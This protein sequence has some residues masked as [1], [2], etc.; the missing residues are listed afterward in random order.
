MSEVVIRVE[1][2]SKEYRLGTI[3]HGTLHRDLQSWWAG[4]RGKDDPNSLMTSSNQ[5]QLNGPNERFWALKDISFDVKK[6]EIVG[7]IG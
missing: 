3:S 4:L 1:N 6:G 5:R 2:L 7:I